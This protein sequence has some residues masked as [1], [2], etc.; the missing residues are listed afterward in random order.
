MPAASLT[1]AKIRK[2]MKSPPEP[3]TVKGKTKGSEVLYFD[4]H[5][6][7]PRGFGV[8]VTSS[9]A[10]SFI[11][12]FRA[13]GRQRRYT[14]GASPDWSL[15]AARKEARD[16]RQVVDQ[17]GDPLADRH[18]RR[19]APTVSELCDHYLD[20]AKATKRASSLAEDRSMMKLFIRPA[21]GRHKVENV[22]RRD[23]EKLFRSIGGN[24]NEPTPEDHP[25]RANRVLSLLS[26]MFGVAIEEGWATTNPAKSSKNGKGGIERY[27]EEAR[28][29]WLSSEEI[30]R[31]LKVLDQH[32]GS[33]ASI[34]KWLLLTGCRAGEARTA[35]WEDFDL[36][37]GTWTKPSHHTKTKTTE[38]VPLSAAA[39]A[40][41]HEIKTA[42]AK[43]IATAKTATAKAQAESEHVFPSLAGGEIERHNL[44]HYW[45]KVRKTAKLDG[46]RI[47]DLRHSFASHLVSSGLSLHVVGMLLGHTQAETTARYAHVADKALREAADVMGS[48][49]ET[50]NNPK[51]DVVDIAAGRK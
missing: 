24:P 12:D 21:L 32:P 1:A 23:V 30:G 14:I 31:L 18:L 13:N 6:D 5:R 25:Y 45:R 39:L 17:G 7:A 11:L 27:R 36:D 34:I 51:A 41:L 35:R 37:R 26:T 16:L 4:H 2:L 20:H 44:G 38:H 33:P 28:E 15:E 19:D 46:V 8:R 22:T 47:H 49:I 48:V 9:G 29:R 43:A 10:V 3:R 42:K 40:F 50:A